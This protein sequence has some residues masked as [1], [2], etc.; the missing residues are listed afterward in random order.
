MSKRKFKVITGP[1]FSSKTTLLLADLERAKLQN[2][3]IMVFKPRMDARYTDTGEIV[4]HSGHKTDAILINSGQDIL[5][6]INNS[7]TM[8][9]I[10]AVDELF[11]IDGSANVLI[12]L[13]FSGIDVLVSSIELS[14]NLRPFEEVQKILPFATKIIKCTAVCTACGADAP[15]TH[16]KTMSDNLIE[17]G[18]QDIYEPRCLLHHGQTIV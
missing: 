4:T 15:Y 2:K 13:F 9:N 7:E 5:D 6:T 18:G 17:V 3:K 14:Y 1:M 12:D 10:V 11:M 16:K 8:P